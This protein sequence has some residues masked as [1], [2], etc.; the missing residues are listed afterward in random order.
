MSDVSNEA[1]PLTDAEIERIEH[2]FAGWLDTS[3]WIPQAM[4]DTRNRP[5]YY[6]TATAAIGCMKRDADRLIAEIKALRAERDLV[7]GAMRAQDEREEA[8]TSIS[9][10]GAIGPIWSAVSGAVG[11]RRYRAEKAERERLAAIV[12]QARSVTKEGVD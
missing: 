5:A 7:R 1:E 9:Y 8:P 4:A 10:L 6:A 11:F 12:A 3:N 2:R